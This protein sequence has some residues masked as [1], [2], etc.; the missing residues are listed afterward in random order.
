M[1]HN[2]N[3]LQCSYIQLNAST[4]DSPLMTFIG[5]SGCEHEPLSSQ[6]KEMVATDIIMPLVVVAQ[7]PG[8]KER[9]S[10]GHEVVTK[11][12]SEKLGLIMAESKYHLMLSFQCSDQPLDVLISEVYSTAYDLAHQ[13]GFMYLIRVWNY[14][15]HI[16]LRQQN[17]ERYQT[18]CVVR[19]Q[20]LEAK[21][22]L[23]QPN[24]AATAI[25][26]HYGRN[27][28]TFLFS[29]QTGQVIENKRQVSAWQYPR[30]YAPK[31]PRFSRA[32]QYGDLLMCSGTA[33]VVGHETIH[34]NDLV[35]QFDECMV[36]IQALLD[37]S[38]LELQ[39]EHGIYRFYLRNKSL[40]SHVL[41]KIKAYGID[42]YV[43]LEGDI[44]RENLLIECE[45]VFQSA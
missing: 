18:F 27:T 43:V 25:G 28:F 4:E 30:Q 16:N 24:P 7:S 2:S 10:D 42:N 44:C 9:W 13:H 35:A 29:R 15:D 39:L 11:S 38:N 26:G 41:S 40:L 8:Y 34:I 14:L 17:E 23:D 22:Q 3:S 20:V 1:D 45:A 5:Q 21:H 33:S 19:H 31:Q 36:N 37:E 6:T 32:M 12:V